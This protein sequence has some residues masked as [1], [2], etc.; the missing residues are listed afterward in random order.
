MNSGERRFGVAYLQ[1]RPL[2]DLVRYWQLVEDAGLHGLW[3]G[4]H[5]TTYPVMGALSELWTTLAAM[6]M[7]TSRIRIG[8][9]VANITY[10]NPTLFAK[11]ALTVDHLSAGRLEVGIGAAGTKLEDGL[12]AGVDAWSTSE[13]A[14]RF[15]EFVEMCD[16]LMS[17]A[18]DTYEGS[19]YRTKGFDRGR[20]PVQRPRPPLTI[21]AHGPRTLRVAAR[22]ADT[23]SVLGGWG[24]TGEELFDFVR[25][26]NARLDAL[27]SEAERSP[28]D[29]RRSLLVGRTG[30]EWW[31]SET[32]LRDFLNSF[33]ECGI[34]DFVFSPMHTP[35]GTDGV[36]R[37]LHLLDA[38]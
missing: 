4:D 16:G 8:A 26:T 19:Y 37:L 11:E 24:R 30:L 22:F 12:V 27:A 32:S 31:E 3:V 33:G 17:G 28:T 20:W 5:L 21:A 7:S 13:R 36:E 35:W 38:V 10:R 25:S 23:W 29:I 9:L 14:S 1:D 6:A 2:D 34:Q 18:I 15:E